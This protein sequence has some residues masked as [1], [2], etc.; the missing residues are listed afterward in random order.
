MENYWNQMHF[1]NKKKRQQNENGSMLVAKIQIKTF[2]NLNRKLNKSKIVKAQNAT[3]KAHI[4]FF[5][6]RKLFIEFLFRFPKLA[7]SFHYFRN[8]FQIAAI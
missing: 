5:H 6:K 2:P 4:V 3:A 8:H 7:V 1:F